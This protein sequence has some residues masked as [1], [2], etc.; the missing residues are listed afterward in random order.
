MLAEREANRADPG[1]VKKGIANLGFQQ[2]S[3]ELSFLGAEKIRPRRRRSCPGYGGL[4][5]GQVLHRLV[6]EVGLP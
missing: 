1:T 5:E 2:T 3:E 4:R 6:H